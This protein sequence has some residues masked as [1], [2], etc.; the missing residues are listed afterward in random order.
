MHNAGRV[1]R[2]G[3]SLARKLR[4][5]EPAVDLN[6]QL[7]DS[8]QYDPTYIQKTRFQLLRERLQKERE[9]GQPATDG[10]GIDWSTVIA[11]PIDSSP[12]H[13]IAVEEGVYWDAFGNVVLNMKYFP[14][15]NYNVLA[16]DLHAKYPSLFRN[17]GGG[18]PGR[19][20]IKWFVRVG[21]A[22]K[23]VAAAARYLPQI[24]LTYSQARSRVISGLAHDSKE[25]PHLNQY[26][27]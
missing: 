8:T 12:T 2:I 13:T 26:R 17:E 15:F 5:S 7:I 1:H 25:V 6:Y 9:N 27:R 19:N 4:K 14:Y 18:V 24:K 22:K 23:L 3:A 11:E 21:L 20:T 16:H 10:F